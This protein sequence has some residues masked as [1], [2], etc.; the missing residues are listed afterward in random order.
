MGGRGEKN[1]PDSLG[2]RVTSAVLRPAGV[3][4]RLCVARRGSNKPF[5]R[6]AAWLGGL[7]LGAG[8]QGNGGLH[9]SWGCQVVLDCGAAK[10]GSKTANLS[11]APFPLQVPALRTEGVAGRSCPKSPLRCFFPSSLPAPGPGGG[12][13][14]AATDREPFP[15]CPPKGSPSAGTLGTRGARPIGDGGRGSEISFGLCLDCYRLSL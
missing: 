11:P 9:T 10:R 6:D 3:G 4:P 13:R 5:C 12:V 15:T 1:P 14:P 8:T 2:E 7:P